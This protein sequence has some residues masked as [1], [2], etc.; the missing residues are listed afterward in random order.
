M[1]VPDGTIRWKMTLPSAAGAPVALM[2]PET[3]AMPPTTAYWI[4][5]TEPNTLYC[6][7]STFV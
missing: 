4:R 5:S 7:N 2:M 1:S 3:H 6:V